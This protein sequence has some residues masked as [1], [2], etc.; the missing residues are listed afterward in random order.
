MGYGLV[1]GE[2]G[3]GKG[4]VARILHYAEPCAQCPMVELN[5]AALPRE[6]SATLMATG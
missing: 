1:G 3:T 2:T 4:L 6:L 5:R